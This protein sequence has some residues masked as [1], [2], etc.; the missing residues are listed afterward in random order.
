MNIRAKYSAPQ[1]SLQCFWPRLARKQKQK[2]QSGLA[3]KLGDAAGQ[4]EANKLTVYSDSSSRVES[5]ERALRSLSRGTRAGQPA[6]Q[7]AGERATKS[8]SW[9]ARVGDGGGQCARC[10]SG[11]ACNH[12]NT[13]R[14]TGGAAAAATETPRRR[15]D[16]ERARGSRGRAH[17]ER[18]LATSTTLQYNVSKRAKATLV[19]AVG[20]LRGAVHTRGPILV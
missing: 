11:A 1:I 13:H 18:A 3:L 12:H 14:P 7:L 15:D 16:R 19:S 2:E 20:L 9:S 5:S 4:S 6:S 17:S 8:C 10:A